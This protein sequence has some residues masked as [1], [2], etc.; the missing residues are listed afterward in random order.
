LALGLGFV[1]VEWTPDVEV[2]QF[3]FDSR[4]AEQTKLD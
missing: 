3:E 4:I 1:P 2:R